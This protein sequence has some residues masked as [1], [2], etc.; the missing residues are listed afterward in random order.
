MIDL[1]EQYFNGFN[2]PVFANVGDAVFADASGNI[3]FAATPPVDPGVADQG[4]ATLVGPSAAGRSLQADFEGKLS[5][6]DS[7][8]RMIVFDPFIQGV[9]VG[10]G[11]GLGLMRWRSFGDGITMF[12]NAELDELGGIRIDLNNGN[13]ASSGFFLGGL[14]LVASETRFFSAVIRNTA[15]GLESS[16]VVLGLWDGFNAGADNEMSA[17]VAEPAEGN[18]L[19]RTKTAGV[20]TTKDTGVANSLNEVTAAIVKTADGFDFYLN[21]AL[22]TSHSTGENIPTGLVDL[23]CEGDAVGSQ[24]I[25]LLAI[26]YLAT[27]GATFNNV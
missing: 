7:P 21:G 12:D 27:R 1:S 6:Q 23:G 18:W 24:T 9:G 17:F 10:G 5:R 8:T 15:F 3:T 25:Q 4:V 22:V 20:A 11:T 16:D 13:D 19:T 14:P 26:Q 2:R